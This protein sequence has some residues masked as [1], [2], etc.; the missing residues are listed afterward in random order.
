MFCLLKS[1]ALKQFQMTRSCLHRCIF[2]SSHRNKSG[3]NC[4]L[5]LGWISSMCSSLRLGE[6]LGAGQPSLLLPPVTA[7]SHLF[8]F[9]CSRKEEGSTS[10]LWRNTFAAITSESSDKVHQKISKIF[11]EKNDPFALGVVLSFFYPRPLQWPSL[12]PGILLQQFLLVGLQRFE[13]NECFK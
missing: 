13:I 3:L 12:Y 5:R 11:E 6:G 10:F 7:T 8:S 4:E 2:S 1:R 9:T